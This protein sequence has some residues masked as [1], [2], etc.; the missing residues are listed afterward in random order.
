MPLLGLLPPMLFRLV[1]KFL[2]TWR[3]LVFGV[4]CLFGA[5]VFAF[6][7]RNG[8]VFVQGRCLNE[9]IW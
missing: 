4:Y 1:S 2:I 9:E 7:S 8:A 6:S 3:L 5:M